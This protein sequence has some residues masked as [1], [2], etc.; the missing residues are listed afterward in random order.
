[1]AWDNVSW[2]L[3]L[4]F[5]KPTLLQIG[6]QV[7]FP[8]KVQH[9]LYGFHVTLAWILGIDEDVIQIHD[10]KDIELFYQDLVDIILEAC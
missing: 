3:Y 8:Q 4:I 2:K 7:I 10:D 9:L 6:K 5:I 1:M